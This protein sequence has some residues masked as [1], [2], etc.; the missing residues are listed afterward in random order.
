MLCV[1][2]KNLE[3]KGVA[4]LKRLRTTD[5]EASSRGPVVKIEDSS[6]RGPGFNP[7]LWRPFFRHH[8]IGSKLETLIVEKL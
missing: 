5:L 1:A 7:P 3:L 8:S 2:N 4:A 6:P